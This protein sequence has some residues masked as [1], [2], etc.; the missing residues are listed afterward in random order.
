MFK[1]LDI[2]VLLIISFFTN[3]LFLTIF[4]DEF[5][6]PL[7][8]LFSLRYIRYLKISMLNLFF[9]L[10]MAFSILF[11][12]IYFSYSFF[13]DV[14]I[15]LV[16]ISMYLL[17][18]ALGDKFLY[19]FIKVI[20][21]LVLL[22][23]PFWIFL[24]FFFILF[25]LETVVNFLKPFSL[26]YSGVDNNARFFSNAR[27]NLLGLFNFTDNTELYYRNFGYMWEPG[28]FASFIAFS[29]LFLEILNSKF[30]Y[31]ISIKYKFV[32]YIG[33][34]SS[35]STAGYIFLMLHVIF[36]GISKSIES[37]KTLFTKRLIA[38]VLLAMI[39]GI[40][41]YNS[42]FIF[43]KISNQFSTNSTD[44]FYYSGRLNFV[45]MFNEIMKS[46]IFGSGTI[47]SI[48]SELLTSASFNA[49][50][51]YVIFIKSWG[52]I[53]FLMMNLMVIN[54]LSNSFKSKL[55][56]F[57]YFVFFLLINF[58]QNH[59]QSFEAFLILFLNN[60]Y[61]SSKSDNFN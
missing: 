60:Y 21:Y 58:S 27:F 13:R 23:I 33:L 29:L 50:N 52:I 8:F 39:F 55:I 28:Q 43:V 44:F 9:F 36:S 59:F 18:S 32:F 40:Y 6:V 5:Y 57:C 49:I 35:F 7:L 14:N 47:T 30:D 25:D 38:I 26:E 2:V 53:L 22:S 10:I 61:Y 1:K 48:S 41:A 11:H 45:Y 15:F 51:G 37:K 19:S 4:P 24:N 56:V 17:I 46:P 20:Y 34:L 16:A 54:T 42:D 12:S 3:P 31:N